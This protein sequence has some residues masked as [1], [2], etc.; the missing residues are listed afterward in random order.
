MYHQSHELPWT[1][2]GRLDY[3]E[4]PQDITVRPNIP[5]ESTFVSLCSS[6]S[7]S[8]HPISHYHHQ[9]PHCQPATLSDKSARMYFPPSHALPEAS[10]PPDPP[11]PPTLLPPPPPL[12]LLP[13]PP[14]KD[15]PDPA[16]QPIPHLLP[17]HSSLLGHQRRRDPLV[18]RHALG[19]QDRAL[20][21]GLGRGP[22]GEAARQTYGGQAA[23]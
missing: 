2:I 13:P 4:G 16:P 12:D 15:A 3:E 8:S 18:A 23:G 21:E 11:D 9:S 19:R 22:G 7:L 10:E 5:K 20:H 6:Q 17:L 1:E 14:L